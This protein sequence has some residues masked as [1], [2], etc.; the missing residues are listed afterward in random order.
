MRLEQWL[1]LTE[2]TALAEDLGSNP[3]PIWWLRESDALLMAHITHVSSHTYTYIFGK[4]KKSEKRISAN[5]YILT[6]YLK[7]FVFH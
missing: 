5:E 2:L 4:K 3:A 6:L 7:L 1:W